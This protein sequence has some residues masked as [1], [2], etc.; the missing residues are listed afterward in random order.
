M[1]EVLSSRKSEK[2]DRGPKADQIARQKNDTGSKTSQIDR[3][4]VMGFLRRVKF[5]GKK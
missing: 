1:I 5:V 4:K 3:E 2:N